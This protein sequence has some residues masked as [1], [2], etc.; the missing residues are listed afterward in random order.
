[1]QTFRLIKSVN[2]SCNIHKLSLIHFVPGLALWN[3][4]GGGGGGE[5]T[6]EF[7]ARY[8]DHNHAHTRRVGSEL[9]PPIGE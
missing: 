9:R 2:Q 8:G 3:G 1:M 6:N 7:T 4:R 5:P